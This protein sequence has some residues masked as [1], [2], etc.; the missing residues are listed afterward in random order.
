MVVRSGPAEGRED[1]FNRW[2]DEVHL[3]EILAVP[4]FVS[5]RR[6]R[7]TAESEYPYLAVYE[8]E[9][10]GALEEPIKAWRALSAAGRTT[11]GAAVRTSPPPVV[12]VYEELSP[13]TRSRRGTD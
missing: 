12:T 2:Y 7:A 4:G 8:I 5:G 10:D 13:S 11:K 1:E 6:Y 9:T 3:P